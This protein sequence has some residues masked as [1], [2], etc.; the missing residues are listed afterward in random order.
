MKK[1]FALI[2]AL[3]MAFS[4]VSA[5][6]AEEYILPYDSAWTVTASSTY[7][8]L[9]IDRVF[10]NDAKTYW[11][12]NYT[13]EG[14]EITGKDEAPHTI[15]VN[16][17]KVVTLSGLIY[18]PRTDNA[19]GIFNTYN[20]YASNDGVKFEL[21]HNGK[22]SYPGGVKAPQK[23]LFDAKKM[24]AIKIRFCDFIDYSLKKWE[25]VI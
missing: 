18:T 16:F 25:K 22:F 10:D 9:T 1:I 23:V 13:A 19:T 5:F 7:K 14:S 12:T 8:N 20:L 24:K 17:G 4:L 2:L 6:A 21:F 15:T 3:L 11:H